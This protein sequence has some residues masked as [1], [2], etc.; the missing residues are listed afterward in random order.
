MKR[1]ILSIVMIITV[2]SV[3]AQRKGDSFVC[4]GDKVNVR[5]GPGTN[6]PVCQLS[7]AI[8]AECDGSEYNGETQKQQLFKGYGTELTHI[9]YLGKHENG[10][11]FVNCY[12]EGEGFGGKGW[13]FAKYLRPQ[14]DACEGYPIIRNS[15]GTITRCR[16]CNG[17]G[18][19]D[20]T[21][22][23]AYSQYPQVNY[24]SKRNVVVNGTN[25]RLRLEPSLQAGWLHDAK[26]NPIY[27]PK[28]A[29]LEYK[30]EKGDFYY[31]FYKNNYVYISKQFSY[32][33]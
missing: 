4:I 27:A 8:I 15:D 29:K 30:G 20:I 26:G 18:Y 19:F 24:Q 21:I 32:I 22:E 11:L 12:E 7:L 16:K 6:Y 33:E 25:V 17:K 31:V 3:A 10:F 9:E 14:C 2:L 28:G 23:Q 1:F 5:T 13:V